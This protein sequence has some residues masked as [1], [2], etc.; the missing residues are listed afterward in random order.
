ME[1]NQPQQP[2]DQPPIQTPTQTPT[3][4]QTPH[5]YP[6]KSHKIR[7]TILISLGVFIAMIAIGGSIAYFSTQSTS[8]AANEFVDAL[9]S[10]DYAKAHS[11]F[12]SSLKNAQSEQ[13][14]EDSLSLAGFDSSCKLNVEGRSTSSSTSSGSYKTITGTIDCGDK[15]FPTELVFIS[16]DDKEVLVKYAIEPAN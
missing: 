5:Q 8:K 9:V 11:Y 13:Q 10:G 4:T 15:K 14:F 16:E 3:Q 2:Q 6:K 1:N 7:N 12:S